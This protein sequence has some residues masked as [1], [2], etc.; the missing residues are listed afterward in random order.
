MTAAVIG[1]VEQAE[2]IEEADLERTAGGGDEQ[3]DEDDVLQGLGAV[4]GLMARSAGFFAALRS[5]RNDNHD[6]TEPCLT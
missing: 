1:A 3:G 2:W 5:A 4:V 6:T